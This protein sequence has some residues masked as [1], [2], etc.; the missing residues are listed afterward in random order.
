MKLYKAG[1][2]ERGPGRASSARTCASP[3]RCWATSTRWSPPTRSAPSGCCASWTSTACTTSARIGRRGAAPLRARDARGAARLPRRRL[4]RGDLQQPARRPAPPAAAD[5]GAGRHDDARFRRRAAAAA[6]RRTNVVYNYTAAYTDLSAEM[7]PQPERA[8]QR[9]RLSSVRRQGAGRLASST[10]RARPRS[11]IRHAP[12]WYAATVR[13]QRAR[14][15]RARAGARRS[16][17]CPSSSTGTARTATARAVRHDVLRRRRGRLAPAA[18][19]SPGCSGRPRRPTPRSRCSRTASRC[20]CS[21]RPS[22]PDSGG[23]GAFRGGLGS[24]LRFRK[25]DDDGVDAAGRGLPGRRRCS[26]ARACSAG[27]AA[28]TRVGPVLDARAADRARAARA[29]W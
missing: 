23:P 22:S 17:D 26:A 25:L 4:S 13:A 9:R 18:T 1:E 12:G 2:R 6:A 3:T 16:P 19:A 5:H 20:S 14:R 21:R 15:R 7:H 11:S 28:A 27:G 24:R 8:R 10:A 29:G